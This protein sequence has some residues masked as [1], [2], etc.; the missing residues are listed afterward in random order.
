MSDFLLLLFDTADFPARWHCGRWSDGHGWLHIG[1]D[2]VTFAAYTAIPIIIAVFMLRR[3]DI[4]FPRV[5]WLF[6]AFIFSCGV[7]HLIEATIFWHPVYRLSGL[8][9]L[10]TA[11][12]STATALSLLWIM[13]E[14][15]RLPGIARLNERLKEEIAERKQREAERERFFALSPD[16]MCILDTTTG[17][18]LNTNGAFARLLDYTPDELRGMMWLELIHPESR[19][20]G[21]ALQQQL[22]Q[23]KELRDWQVRCRSKSGAYLWMDWSIAPTEDRC[24]ATARDIG[25]RL[26]MEA[27]RRAYEER[28]N[29]SQRLESLGLLAGGIAHDFN[30]LL[31]S[32]LGNIDLLRLDLDPTH[33]GQESVEQL[34]LASRQATD[35]CKQMLAYSGRGRF[36]VQRVD[37]STVIA[38]VTDL[39]RLSVAPQ[40]ELEL[41]LAATP[42]MVHADTTQL[43]QVVM[44]LVTN[45]SE[46]VGGEPG[47]V[48]VT[49]Q[50]LE[51]SH[52]ELKRSSLPMTTTLQP[53]VYSRVEVSDTGV[54]MD[55][56]TQARIFEPF[57]STKFTGRGLG[58]AA[59]QGIVQAH[60]GAIHVESAPGEGTTVTI[61]LPFAP[62]D[63][64]SPPRLIEPPPPRDA[65]SDASE[66]RGVILVVDDERAVRRTAKRLLTRAGFEVLL[67]EDGQ[68]GLDMALAHG[69]TIGLI[70]LDMTMPELNGSEVLRQ[71]RGQGVS[72]PILLSSGYSADE[73]I[74][75]HGVEP[76]GFLPKPYTSKEL[77]AV[78][79]EHFE[80]PA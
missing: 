13:P 18:F 55:E 47:R 66:R 38:D 49:T 25:D 7:V 37:L 10:I 61:D 4:A 73:V 72:T 69:D 53:G 32:M 56:L 27:E 3:R 50:V 33:P 77:L 9:K 5:F 52:G 78:I 29:N 11:V 16:L 28:L 65:S 67:A 35:L 41:Q 75:V 21:E 54:G 20:E 60:G 14:A 24:Y 45:A 70:L 46:A 51:L 23:G 31:T 76:D 2:L 44:N 6:V 12:V 26:E 40:V 42:C 22:Q 63:L 59:V 80:P 74:A 64:Q 57:F 15:L 19:S 30:N 34:E 17:H 79:D 62:R 39:L 1:S 8:M 36:V 43:R 71:L 58:L 48:T 68:E